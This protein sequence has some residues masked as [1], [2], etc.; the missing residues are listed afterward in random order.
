[1]KWLYSLFI[2]RIYNTYMHII[3]NTLVEVDLCWNDCMMHHCVG[4][5][6]DNK[7]DNTRQTQCNTVDTTVL[8]IDD[9]DDDDITDSHRWQQLLQ[10]LS[11]VCVIMSMEIMFCIWTVFH[12][13][14]VVSK[15]RMLV[16]S[17]DHFSVCT[18]CLERWIATVK[19]SWH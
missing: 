7:A 14:V 9:D 11:L 6:A 8:L 3:V 5:G 13:C 15:P 1:M 4:A 19:N 18:I 2:A 16:M 12:Y 10:Q 17:P